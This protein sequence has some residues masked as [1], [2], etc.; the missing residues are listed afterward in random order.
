[1]STFRWIFLKDG[2]NSEYTLQNI[3]A[4]ERPVGQQG[5]KKGNFLFIKI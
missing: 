1:M 4:T 3:H 2:I 5:N